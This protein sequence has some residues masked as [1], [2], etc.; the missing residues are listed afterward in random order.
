M[1]CALVASSLGNL[2]N[3]AATFL[4][5]KKSVVDTAHSRKLCPRGCSFFPW[6]CSS[7]S[8]S[9]VLSLCHVPISVLLSMFSL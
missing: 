8:L 2:F 4:C 5:R 9:Q 6:A 7:F 3:T 1:V